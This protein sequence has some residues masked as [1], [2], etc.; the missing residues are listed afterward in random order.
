MTSDLVLVTGGAGFLGR[1]VVAELL[2]A[3]LRVRVLDTAEGF[4][5]AGLEWIRG[6]VADPAIVKQA[7][8]D[9]SQVI[10]LAA[11]PHLWTDDVR[12]FDRVNHHGTQ[13]MLDEA[14]QQGIAAFVH[15]SSLT[16]RIS[17]SIGGD[18][19][20]VR[21]SDIPPLTAMLG[22]YPRSKWRAEA[23]A[24]AAASDALPVRIAIPTMPMGP[25]DVNMT[26]PS[27]MVLDFVTGGTPAY[28]ETWMNIA[29]VRDMA[30]GIVSL[31]SREVPPHGVFVAGRNTQLSEVLGHLES[32]SGVSMPRAKVPGL[33]AE[34][35]ATVDEF[36][37]TQFTH[38]PPKAPLTGVRLAR[39]P[40]IFD[41]SLS[42]ALLP[43]RAYTLD[44]TLA[45]LL[46]WFSRE[47]LWHRSN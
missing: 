2:K 28:L 9:V 36:V 25:G 23:A 16:T 38:R 15:V 18:P 45:D 5:R 30:T 27:R 37:S 6:T 8:V 33:V 1:H 12:D 4:A 35:F 43:A 17:G 42:D 44:Q 31:L 41:Q 29:D 20:L 46:S 14:R 26:P 32:I 19:R 11:I 34:A 47:G 24:R 21:E 39:R 40:V 22:A 7:Y 3:G 10:H 13:V